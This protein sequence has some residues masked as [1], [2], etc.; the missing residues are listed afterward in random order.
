M[1]PHP[2]DLFSLVAGLSLVA[3]G[4]AGFAGGVDLAGIERS[5]IVPIALL[6]IAAGIA[7]TLWRSA[8]RSSTRG[9]ERDRPEQAGI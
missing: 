6:A 7:S 5:A 3:L 1:K 2:F 4:I 9:D 8:D